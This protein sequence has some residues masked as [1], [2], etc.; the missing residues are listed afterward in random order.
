MKFVNPMPMVRD[1]QVKG[2][3]VPAFN[4]TT[5]QG[6][7]AEVVLLGLFILDRLTACAVAREQ[8]MRLFGGDVTAA[9]WGVV[10]I[11]GL[12]VPVVLELLELSG[13][14]LPTRAAPILILLGGFGLR[15]V[16][17]CSGQAL[18]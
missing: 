10:V 13:K 6:I 12:A 16:L 5:I 7:G 11:S 17:V 1:A 9:F 3:A 15:C 18:S 14:H 8:V 4:V 2:Y